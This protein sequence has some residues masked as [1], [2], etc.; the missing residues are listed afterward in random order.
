VATIHTSCR[1]DPG[2][3]REIAGELSES[4]LE[5]PDYIEALT[6]L[7]VL[8]HYLRDTDRKTLAEIIAGQVAP[9]K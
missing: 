6:N 1:L 4:S 7:V 2:Y 3:G 9:K 8:F 5:D